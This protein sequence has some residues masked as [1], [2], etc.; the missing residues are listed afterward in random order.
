MCHFFSPAFLVKTAGWW[1]NTP[2]ALETAL[3]G[4][5]EVSIPDLVPKLCLKT[6]LWLLLLGVFENFT[7]LL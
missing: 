6:E 7:P 4:G 1:S 2:A 3:L 5:G